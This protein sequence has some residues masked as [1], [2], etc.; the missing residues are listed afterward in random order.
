MNAFLGRC[1]YGG[2][3]FWSIV[4]PIYLICLASLVRS[5]GKTHI[6]CSTI[7]ITE[8]EASLY[9]R[10]VRDMLGEALNTL[11]QINKRQAQI[12]IQAADLDDNGSREILARVVHSGYCGSAGCR[13]LVLTEAGEGRWSTLLG[14]TRRIHWSR[15]HVEQRLV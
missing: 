10:I 7:G 12:E 5:E 4:I 6:I 8:S 1:I 13:I 2:R 11:E 14:R 9:T 3:A 15:W